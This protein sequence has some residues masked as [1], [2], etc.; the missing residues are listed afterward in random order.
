MSAYELSPLGTNKFV[1]GSTKQTLKENILKSLIQSVVVTGVFAAPVISF[2]QQSNTPLARA[3]VYAQLVQIEK[4]GYDP[5][6]GINVDYPAR[7]QAAEARVAARSGAEPAAPT[8]PS[9][10]APNES[11]RE[12]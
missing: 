11:H 3:Q 8:Q 7:I 4:A 6:G 5:R 9:G 10:G 12:Q 1:R 2:A